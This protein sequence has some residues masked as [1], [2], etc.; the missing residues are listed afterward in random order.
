MTVVKIKAS[1]IAR[2]PEENIDG[3]SSKLI[4]SMSIIYLL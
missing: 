4:K 1:G 3:L 2:K